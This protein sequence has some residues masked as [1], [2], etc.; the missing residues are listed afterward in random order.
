MDRKTTIFVI[1]LIVCGLLLVSTASMYIKYNKAKVTL[2]EQADSIERL[3]SLVSSQEVT[4]EQK[5]AVIA[6]LQPT[7]DAQNLKIDGLEDDKILLSNMSKRYCESANA[8]TVLINKLVDFINDFTVSGRASP[9]S[10]L[11]TIFD[12]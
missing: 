7:I 6:N 2:N 3:Y 11:T 5:N 1:A 9:L 10:H 8:N 12:C 4:I